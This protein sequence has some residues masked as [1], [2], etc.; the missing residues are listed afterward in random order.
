MEA[1]T[2]GDGQQL[3]VADAGFELE[4]DEQTAKAPLAADAIDQLR[5]R[6][7]RSHNSGSSL[8]TLPA[9]RSTSAGPLVSPLSHRPLSGR[10]C[11]PST[12]A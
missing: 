9:A 1:R 4:L 2:L 7:S 6:T 10:K 5:R 3:L 11:V 8:L 12:G